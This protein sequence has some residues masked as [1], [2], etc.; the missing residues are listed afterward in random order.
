MLNSDA[1]EYGG[2][3]VGNAGGLVTEPVLW[4]NKKQ[5]LLVKLPP[6]GLVVFKYR[7]T[8]EENTASEEQAQ[9]DV[10]ND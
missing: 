3:G 1:K 7:K 6:L 8:E 9:T 2:S 10:Q 4:H 5:S